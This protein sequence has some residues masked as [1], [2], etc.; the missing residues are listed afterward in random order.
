MHWITR[1]Y[2]SLLS[3]FCC[4]CSRLDGSFIDFRIRGKL[5]KLFF[6]LIEGVIGL[7]IA[8]AGGRMDTLVLQQV[9]LIQKV[10]DA[11]YPPSSPP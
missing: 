3:V 9:S 6:G 10:W 2:C 11:T 7:V 4:V 1:N 8:I 5:F